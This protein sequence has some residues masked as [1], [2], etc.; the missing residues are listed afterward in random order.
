MFVHRDDA[1]VIWLNLD[2]GY[3]QTIH[4]FLVVAV[5]VLNELS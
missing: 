3:A 4:A 2:L 1:L 5:A